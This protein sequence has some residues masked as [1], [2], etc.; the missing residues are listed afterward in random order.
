[1]LYSKTFLL[2]SL[3]FSGAFATGDTFTPQSS[4]LADVHW[5]VRQPVASHFIDY[6]I[7]DQFID[8]AIPDKM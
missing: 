2:Y 1:V 4:L 8:D 6:A 5:C 3:Y 7:P